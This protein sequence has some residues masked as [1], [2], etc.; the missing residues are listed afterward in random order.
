M[1][2]YEPTAKTIKYVFIFAIFIFLCCKKKTVQDNRLPNDDFSQNS[3]EAISLLGDTLF[4]PKALPSKTLDHY[5]KTK[6][7]YL[8]NPKNVENL[9][10]Y[11][12]RA[13][14]LDHFQKA[15][16]I[17][18]EGIR[19]FPKEPRFYR[20]RGHRYISTRQYGNAIEDFE[21][22]VALVEGKPD[23][24]EPDGIPN[25]RN[26]P[27]SSLQGNIW[28]HLGLAHYLK[29]DLEKSLLAFRNRKN[30]N[31]Y[32]DNWVSGGHWLYMILKRMG[33][34]KEAEEAIA[35]VN[36]DMDII[37]NTNYHKMCL[38]YKGILTEENIRPKSDGSSSDDVFLYGLGNWYLYQKKDTL[39]AKRLFKTL[40]DKGNRYSFAYLAAESDWK[41]H[42][43]E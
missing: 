6:A 10:W 22:A 28:Y 8:K 31:T 17:Y 4:T 27:I 41:H 34:D 40:L 35:M 12:R 38:F 1:K 20:H 11:G 26:I 39:S 15:I 33:K 43:R 18:S 19:Q 3:I 2:P 13:A 32:D 29:G 30:T 36:T 23:E 16:G 14:Y 24:I 9:I 21:K 37:E 25:A 5:K 42:F 7:R